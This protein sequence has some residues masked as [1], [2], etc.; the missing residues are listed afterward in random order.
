MNILIK[1]LLYPAKCICCDDVL[2]FDRYSYGICRRCATNVRFAREPICKM[3]G[4]VIADDNEELCADC[5]K[6]KHYF[7]QSRGVFVYEGGIKSAMYRFKY[8]NRRCFAYTFTGYAIKM[9]A[10]WIR[11]HGI[12]AII[13]VP[14]YKHKKRQ[15]G[16]NQ[17]EVIAGA[18]GKA[19]DIPVYRDMVVRSRATTPM[20]GLS[21]IQR[22]KNLKNAFNFREKGI[23]LRRVLIVDD[24]Y[25]TGATLDSVAGVLLR[26]GISEVYGLCICV[27]RGYS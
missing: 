4:K 10:S 21:D 16:Y 8:N 22:Q 3:C 7:V 25:T 11:G 20:K 26:G 12:E 9:H 17:A 1:Y 19:L 14:M 27:G 18:L 13:P 5:K 23:Q 24:I 2:D 15:R 6:R